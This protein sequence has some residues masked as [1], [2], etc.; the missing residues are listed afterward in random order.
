MEINQSFK[1][2]D[3]EDSMNPSEKSLS[4]A[5]KSKLYW[6]FLILGYGAAVPWNE[7]LMGMVYF[8]IHYKEKFKPE[9]TFPMAFFLP[10]IGFKL[11]LITYGNYFPIKA[12]LIG[13][14]AMLTLFSYILILFIRCTGSS[15]LSFSFAVVIILILGIL[16]DIIQSTINS[17]AVALDS[18][19]LLPPV[20][21]GKRIASV[22]IGGLMIL[23]ML[24]IECEKEHCFGPAMLFFLIS[25]FTIIGA[26]YIAYSLLE[27][28]FVSEILK[29]MPQPKSLSQRFEHGSSIFKS[30]GKDILI[31]LLLTFTVFPG[32]LIGKT[33]DSIWSIPIVILLFNFCDTLGRML[34]HFFKVLNTNWVTYTTFIRILFVAFACVV[35]YVNCSLLVFAISNLIL[36]GFTNGLVNNL[37][38]RYEIDDSYDEEKEDIFILLSFF[39]SIGIVIG[40]LIAQFVF[41]FIGH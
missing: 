10:S 23:C 33:F 16:Y 27:N 31:T 1:G 26:T 20:V 32:I 4:P 28:P 29:Q 19:N 11:L 39:G 24:L 18:G 3:L 14:F 34:A 15:I 12:K 8:K 9:F 38:L 5:L 22:F 25:S 35:Y 37:A 13:G 36:L 41:A 30:H 40:T 6:Y 7:V 17:L 2:D 21:I